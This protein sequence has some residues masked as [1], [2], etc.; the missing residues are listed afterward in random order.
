ML[1]G[2]ILAAAILKLTKI[3]GEFLGHLNV[4]ETKTQVCGSTLTK[5]GQQKM[6]Q[7]KESQLCHLPR[8]GFFLCRGFKFSVSGRVLS[9]DKT[10]HLIE[11]LDLLVYDASKK[12]PKNINP[13]GDL[14]VMCLGTIGKR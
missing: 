1:G 7:K 11:H 12:I 13:N 10:C 5:V 4:P 2:R 6:Q 14:L 8:H 3:L 9:P